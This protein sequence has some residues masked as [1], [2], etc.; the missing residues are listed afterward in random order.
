MKAVVVGAGIAGLVAARQL[1]LAGWDVEILEKSATPRPD[2]YMMDFF[3]PGVGARKR[4][5]STR[6]SLPWRTTSRRPSMSIRQ[7]AP[8]RV[9][10][11]TGLP[12]LPA[13]RS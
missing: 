13:G 11:T 2:G 3:G 9:S 12:G 10:T 4:L 8:G 7:D 5:A 1:G 6:G